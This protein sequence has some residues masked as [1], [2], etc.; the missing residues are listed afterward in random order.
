MESPYAAGPQLASPRQTLR[1]GAGASGSFTPWRPWSSSFS[2]PGQFF[3]D[4]QTVPLNSCSPTLTRSTAPW[5][6]A[7]REQNHA[8]VHLERGT[9]SS[10]L[11][12]PGSLLRAE[13]I[14]AEHLRN[15]PNSVEFLDAKARA[16]LID[17]NFDSAIQSVQRAMETQPLSPVLM[18]DLATAYFAR[19]EGYRPGH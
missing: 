10:N 8:P 16:D 18:T 12:K 5:N 2:P 7:S 11:D 1:R 14:I 4:C 19:A 13:A 6:Y 17:G 15:N 3:I 9:G